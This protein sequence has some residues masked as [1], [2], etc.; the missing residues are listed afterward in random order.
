MNLGYTVLGKMKIIIFY[1]FL[2]ME[3]ITILLIFFFYIYVCYTVCSPA[4]GKNAQF[5]IDFGW[6]TLG[7]KLLCE[8]LC[9]YPHSQNEM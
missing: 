9:E 2:L 4:V 5:L 8:Q 1:Y 3:K 7:F 6:W